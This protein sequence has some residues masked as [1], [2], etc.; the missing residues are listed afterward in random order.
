[1]QGCYYQRSSHKAFCRKLVLSLSLSNHIS[2]AVG[3]CSEDQMFPSH[4]LHNCDLWLAFPPCKPSSGGTALYRVGIKASQ[5]DILYLKPFS[6]A[7]S[8]K[9]CN[10]DLPI[11]LLQQHY[12]TQLIITFTPQ[13]VVVD[14]PPR[15][16][17]PQKS[18]HLFTDES[19]NE[20][21]PI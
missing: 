9:D 11:G 21:C 5:F 10:W 16:F 7:G 1:M 18:F 17:W 20:Y 15:G 6:V 19:S 2:N 3:Q 8:C 12:C 4:W 13:A 14:S